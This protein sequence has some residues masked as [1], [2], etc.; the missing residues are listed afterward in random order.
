LRLSRNGRANMERM[1]ELVEILNRAGESYYR[2]SQE[3]MSNLEYDGLYDEL[4]ALEK[5]TGIVLSNSPTVKVGGEVL[6]FLPKE[7]H[8]APML[9]LNKTKDSQELVNFLGEKEGVLSWKLDG[10]TVVLTYRDGELTKAVTRGN[11][12]VG[13]VITNNAKAFQNLPLKIPY[14]GKA[15]I[16]GEAVISYSDFEEINQA[17]LEVASKYKNPR[18]LCS[19]SVRQLNPEITRKRKVRFYAFGLMGAEEISLSS[20]WEQLEWVEAQGFSVVEHRRTKEAVLEQDLAYFASRVEDLDLPSDGLVLTFNDIAYG[21]TLGVTS[22]FPR[23]AMAYKWTDEM[24]E[25]TLIQVEWNASRTGL[26]NPIA[27]FEPVELE[28]TT[29]SRASVHNVSIVK[30]LRLGIGDRIMVYKANMI[31]PQISQNITGSGSVKVPDQCPACREPAF[32]KKE[33]EVEVLLCL[34]ANCPAK[35]IKSYSLLVSR[36]AL[37]VDG[38]S[39]ATLEKLIGM[40]LI[41]EPADLFRLEKN[42]EARE[43]IVSMEGFGE[44]SYRNL[45]NSLNNS[46]KTTAARLLYGLGIPNIGTANAKAIAAYSNH[47][48]RKMMEW[49]REDLEEIPGVGL[50][51][52]NGYV[53]YFQ[54]DRRRE[55]VERLL[56]ELELETGKEEVR[57]QMLQGKTFVITGATNLFQNREE[58]KEFIESRGGKVAGSVSSKTHYLIN[59][60]K[61]SS[62]TKNKAAKSLG[63]PILTE[64]EFLG[65]MKEEGG[66]ESC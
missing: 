20:R 64:E 29:V 3:V 46:R 35:E 14:K 16:R 21:A 60:E 57:P 48:F 62:S 34:N 13:E 33:K 45:I 24:A 11:G 7:A 54:E 1:K 27:I 53:Q 56:P 58:M 23:D 19:G 61:N 9:S 28:G 8:E 38:L 44:K 2:E 65:W 25:T 4:V 50:V 22:K 15:V 30:E 32:L 17:I 47:D 52:A 63:I 42:P 41:H 6:D 55:A 59:N 39:E 40:G 10:L 37:N 18:N 36:N 31:I 49:S 51:L 5:E 43:K 66:E 26:I 12:E